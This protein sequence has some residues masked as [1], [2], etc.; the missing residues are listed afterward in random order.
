M[1]DGIPFDQDKVGLASRFNGRARDA[2]EVEIKFLVS[3]GNPRAFRKIERHFKNRN[4]VLA[5]GRTHLVTRQ[6]DTPDRSLLSKGITIRVRGHCDDSD[7]N[8][9]LTPDVCIKTGAEMDES[10]AL[11]RGEYQ[12]RIGR[13]DEVVVEPLLERYASEDY[14]EVHRIIEHLDM[15]SLKEFF[16]IDC[17]RTRYVVE[18]PESETGLVGKRF[19]AELLLD[20]VIYILDIPELDKPLVFHHDREIECEALF[21]PCEFDESLDSYTRVSSPLTQE[22]LDRAMKVVRGHIGDAAWNRLKPNDLSKA[23]R[24][25]NALDKLLAVLSAYFPQERNPEAGQ[26]EILKKTFASRSF[27]GGGAVFTIPDMKFPLKRPIALR[28]PLM[29]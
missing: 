8:H 3:N 2:E 17:Q 21:K 10:G 16:R 7:L 19:V 14:A 1:S 9:V 15:T 20:D 28:R 13:F 11:R 27:G 23:E 25:F 6:L 29:G 22:E 18:L 12:A 24:G 5:E 4:W 26:P